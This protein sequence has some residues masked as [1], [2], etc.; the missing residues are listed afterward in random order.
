[1]N[2]EVERM[3]FLKRKRDVLLAVYHEPSTMNH[4]LFKRK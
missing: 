3:F 4:E 2:E 1:M